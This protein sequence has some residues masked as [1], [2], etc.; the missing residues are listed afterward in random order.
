[1]FASSQTDHLCH[2]AAGSTH[3]ERIP[4]VMVKLFTITVMY[5]NVILK[6][7]IFSTARTSVINK[8]KKKNKEKNFFFLNN[9]IHY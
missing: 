4:H 8:N 7:R 6:Y 5:T 1:M 9:V 3:N 2:Y